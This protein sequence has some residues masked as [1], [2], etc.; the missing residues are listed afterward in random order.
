MVL[1]AAAAAVVVAATEAAAEAAV[2][3]TMATA[4]VVVVMLVVP[5]CVSSRF[6]PVLVNK[7]RAEGRGQAC[8]ALQ[9]H[10]VDIEEV[11]AIRKEPPAELPGSGSPAGS[12]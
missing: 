7:C 10:H 3:T 1:V 11:V 8:E 12:K 9:A 2:T 5:L 6:R 4:V